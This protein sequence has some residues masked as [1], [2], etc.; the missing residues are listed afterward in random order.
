M[1]TEPEDAAARERALDPERSFL[2]QAPA[3]SGKTELLTR[4]YLRL[5]ATVDA[6]EEVLAITFTRKAAGEMRARILEALRAP[7]ADDPHRARTHALAQAVRRRDRELDWGLAQHP[8]RLRIQTIDSLCAGLTRR[9]PWV[10]RFGA[11]PT[12]AEPF[13]ALYREAARATLR[14]VETGSRWSEAVAR[15][16]LHLDNDFPRVESLLVDLLGRRDQWQRHLRRR[17]ELES[18]ALRRELETV[19]AR[20]IGAR[21]AALRARLAAAAG[22]ALVRLADYAGRTLA[23]KGADSP[24]VACAGLDA[25]PAADATGLERWR[26]IAAL[27]LTQDGAWRRTLNATSGVPAGKDP[28][29]ARMRAAGLELLQG[30]ADDTALAAAL[31]AVRALP[32]PRYEDGQWTLLQAL[33]ELLHLALAQLRVVFQAHGR[34]DYVEIE[35]AAVE[36]LGAEDAPTDLALAL[37]HR[38]R[39]ILVDEFQDSSYSHYELLRRLTAGWAPGD[40]RTLF[41]VGDPMQSIYRFREADVGLYLDA[42]AHGIGALSLE[43]LYLSANFRA[44][45][46]LIDWINAT[47]PAVFPAAEDAGAGAVAYRAC[48]AVRAREPGPAVEVHA[49]VDPEPGA[50]T[51]T[52]LRLIAA[53]RASDPEGRIAVLVR[54]RSHLDALLPALRRA[55]IAFLALDVDALGEHPAARDLLALTRALLHPAD[56]IAWLSVLRAPWCG[57]TLADLHA[58]VDGAAADAPVPELWGDPARV[59]ALSAAGRARL[60]R[61]VAVLEAALAE[62]GRRGLA[63]WIEGTW[64]ALG[65]PACT[66]A[67]GFEAARRYL[68]LLDELDAGGDLEDPAMLE[69]RLAQLRAPADPTAGESVQILSIHKA[70]GL[71]FDTVIVPGLER[72]PRPRGRPLLR[73]IER[74]GRDG[75]ELLLAPIAAAGADE[76]P[77][78][79]YLRDLEAAA[80]RHEA[81][82][83]LYVACTR[84]R[85]RLHLIG[86]ARGAD[87][88][89]EPPPAD[90]LLALLW[91]ALR[92]RFEA[93]A[94]R[95]AAGDLAPATPPRSA[96]PLLRLPAGWRAPAPPPPAWTAPPPARVLHAA[97]VAF[98]W[99]GDTARHVGTVVHRILRRIAHEGLDTWDAGRLA[100]AQGAWRA[101]LRRLGVAPGELDA[102]CARVHAALAAVLDDPRA[103]WILAADHTQARN[104]WAVHGVVDGVIRRVVIDRTFVD[105]AGRRWII[106]YKTGVHAGAGVE[107]FLDRE[108]ERYR[109]QLE[110]Y[111]ALLARLDARPLRLGLYFPLLRG[112]REW[113][114]EGGG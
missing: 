42:R 39:H 13:D 68:A 70:K 74:R 94:A 58:L 15:L 84:A 21:L 112:W 32:P 86:A 78:Y 103:H 109:A 93:A 56:R 20:E 102:A 71:E 69:E 29:A 12:V 88:G 77:I 73:W 16:L 17:A 19:L 72:P 55:G 33:F 95:A 91:P 79:R 24:I 11:P 64:L 114:P 98:E 10:T 26:G 46:G 99:A 51:E 61:A 25:L 18:G 97:A 27:L 30:L 28:E 62:R 45:A 36:A 43:P 66:D 41:V 108:R 105:G 63:A 106:D 47:F 82:R 67:A 50:Q 87:G 38:V 54:A 65:G 34:V 5:L 53:A 49:L 1:T 75:A 35:Q 7:A 104:E 8:A 52:I 100:R 83:V 113:E 40:G 2:V 48:R 22:D 59:A 81:A 44:A 89:L 37:D 6:P 80:D 60:E 57:L 90:S 107:A 4:R 96:P 31:H 101:A 92:P 110:A 85:R 76:D 14:S 111:A 9:L 23:R 3:G